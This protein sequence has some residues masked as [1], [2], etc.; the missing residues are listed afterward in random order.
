[1]KKIVTFLFMLLAVSAFAQNDGKKDAAEWREQMKEQKRAVLISEMGLTETEKTAFL[2]LYDKFEADQ[3]ALNRETH[4]VRKKINAEYT[5][6]QYETVNEKLR[7][8][9]KK[10]CDM[11]DRFYLDMKK[12][13]SAEKIYKFYEAEHKF[14]KSVFKDLRKARARKQ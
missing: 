12:I 10:R 8:L 7:E 5:D 13:L 2:A 14:N 6:K 9:N 1:M 11:H 3:W 4:Q